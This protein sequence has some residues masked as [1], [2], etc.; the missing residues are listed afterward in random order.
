MDTK[1]DLGQGQWWELKPKLSHGDYRKVEKAGFQTVREMAPI[2]KDLNFSTEELQKMQDRRADQRAVDSE[3]AN[4]V[5][6]APDLSSDQEDVQL[7]C[8]TVGWSFPEDVNAES[9]AQRD[10]DQVQ[11]MLAKCRELYRKR[12]ADE[13]E[14]L[15]KG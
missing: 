4:G 15:K 14:A 1:V 6:P 2:M 10:G 12:S 11:V 5:A 13:R 9:I 7:L 8:A 3:H